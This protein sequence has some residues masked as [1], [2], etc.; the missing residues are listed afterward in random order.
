MQ[1]LLPFLKPA[2]ILWPFQRG[3]EAPP[4]PRTALVELTRDL[5]TPD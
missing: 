4:S 2:N 5:L 1:A 3:Y